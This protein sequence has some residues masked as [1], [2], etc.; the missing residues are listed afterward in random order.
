MPCSGCVYSAGEVRPAGF[1]S[2]TSISRVPCSSFVIEVK[3]SEF[4][5]AGETRCTLSYLGYETAHLALSVQRAIMASAT[6]CAF[7]AAS[8]SAGTKAVATSTP[9]PLPKLIVKSGTCGHVSVNGCLLCCHQ[10]DSSTLLY[11]Q[12]SVQG[13][14]LLPL[15]NR[16]QTH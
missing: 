4:I 1:K 7:L 5:R 14:C 12:M 15:L 10:T 16:G 11:S 9:R 8:T 2:E 13:T 6:A 3:G